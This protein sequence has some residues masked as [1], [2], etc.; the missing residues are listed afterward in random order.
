MWT[1]TR[2]QRQRRGAGQEDQKAAATSQGAGPG[3]DSPS[4]PQKE[5]ALPTPRTW[6]SGF[7]GASS[8]QRRRAH[9]LRGQRA[10]RLGVFSELE[11]HGTQCVTP[12]QR[13]RAAPGARSGGLPFCHRHGRSGSPTSAGPSPSVCTWGAPGNPAGTLKGHLE[14]TVS[15]HRGALRTHVA[16][17]TWRFFWCFKQS[18]TF[19]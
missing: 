18:L 10:I 4:Q 12:E 11:L 14:E 3:T 1:E 2:P 13:L 5:P 15:S 6:T 8:R 17:V 19:R 16:A 7:R 9:V